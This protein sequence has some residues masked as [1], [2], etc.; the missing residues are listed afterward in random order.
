MLT[1]YGKAFG[2]F[3]GICFGRD[4]SEDVRWKR[5]EGRCNRKYSFVRCLNL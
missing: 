3:A 4:G 2:S 1:A 5:A